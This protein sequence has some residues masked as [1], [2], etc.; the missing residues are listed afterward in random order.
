MQTDAIW[1]VLRNC[2][3]GFCS[4]NHPILGLLT[5]GNHYDGGCAS[6]HLLCPIFFL[7]MLYHI[8]CDENEFCVTDG[9]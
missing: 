3:G 1:P 4:V 8:F 7:V 5:V 6:I 2:Q 9:V